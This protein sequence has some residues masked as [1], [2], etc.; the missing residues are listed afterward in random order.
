[1]HVTFE[2]G[3]CVH[4]IPHRLLMMHFISTSLA[5]DDERWNFYL[6]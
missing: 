2:I 1:M 4:L 5:T 6:L 3:L